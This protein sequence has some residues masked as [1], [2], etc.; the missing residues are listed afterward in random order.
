[1][2]L[3]KVIIHMTTV[4]MS[5]MKLLVQ[6]G[7]QIVWVI[8]VLGVVVFCVGFYGSQLSA[9]GFAALDVRNFVII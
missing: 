6:Q 5:V 2:T 1:M 8:V 4:Y 9:H 3:L 7:C